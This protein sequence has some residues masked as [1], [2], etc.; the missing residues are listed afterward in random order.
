M[1]KLNHACRTGGHTG[2]PARARAVTGVKGY[3]SRTSLKLVRGLGSTLAGRSVV[4]HSHHAKPDG[5]STDP[6]VILDRLGKV[7][8]LIKLCSVI[9]TSQCSACVGIRGA[10]ALFGLMK[11]RAKWAPL[12]SPSTSCGQGL[13]GFSML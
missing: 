11:G 10:L 7:S 5:P 13:L 3:A 12:L 8:T 9:A 4:A 2:H 6:R 1:L